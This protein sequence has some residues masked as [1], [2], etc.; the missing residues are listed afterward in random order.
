MIIKICG[1]REEEN[2]KEISLLKPDYMGFIFYPKSPRNAYHIL[3]E[4]VKRLPS[5]IKRT[6]VFVNS[7]FEEIMRIA[8]KYNLHTVQLHGEE[9]TELCGNL[10]NQGLEVIKAFKIKSSDSN[11][12]MSNLLPYKDYVDL[13][14]FDTA[15][16]A[17]GGN[18]NK[19][20]WEI[21]SNY[22]LT[23]P[24]LLSG[25]I[26]PEDSKT[27]KRG[28]PPQCLGIDVNSKFEISPGYKNI[29]KLKLFLDSL[30]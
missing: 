17:P 13:F 1:L 12:L 20:D 29:S 14:L 11:I 24:Y 15:G 3:P 27:L 22:N 18:G 19:F 2:I 26:G 8:D 9:S 30:Q 4:T 5:Q 28:L 7:T 16:A 21:L 25:G 6:G 23:K 10:K